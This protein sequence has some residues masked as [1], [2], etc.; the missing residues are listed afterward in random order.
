MYDFIYQQNL[1]FVLFRNWKVFRQKFVHYCSETSPPFY[2]RELE[3][4][5]IGTHMTCKVTS[6]NTKQS[7]RCL[8]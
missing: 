8:T 4:T 3:Y 7:R 5:P 6:S 2:P 1:N